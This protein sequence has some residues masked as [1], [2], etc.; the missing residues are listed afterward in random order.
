MKKYGG[1]DVLTYA[2]LTSALVG[3][4][5]STSRSG[6]FTYV[7]RAPIPCVHEAEWAPELYNV[8]HL[9]LQTTGRLISINKQQKLRDF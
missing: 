1:V 5:W 3:S 8:I 2:F 6:R 7:E 9:Q 4:Q